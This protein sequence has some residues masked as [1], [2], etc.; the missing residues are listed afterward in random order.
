MGGGEFTGSLLDAPPGTLFDQNIQ[1]TNWEAQVTC[2]VDNCSQNPAPTPPTPIPIPTAMPPTLSPSVM[3]FQPVNSPSN[4]SPP[5]EGS[6]PCCPSDYTGLK[7][8][9]HCLQYYHCVGGVVTGQLLDAPPG[10]LFDQSIQNVN[11]EAQVTC[12]VDV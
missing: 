9:N 12:I 4:P 5:T 7:A 2:I 10:T 8:W 1:N 3:T 11:W 6:S